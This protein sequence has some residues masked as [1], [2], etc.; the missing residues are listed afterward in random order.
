MPIAEIAICMTF[1]KNTDKQLNFSAQ[2]LVAL[3]YDFVIFEFPTEDGQEQD[4][5]VEPEAPVFD[6]IDIIPDPLRDRGVAPQVIHLCPAGDSR[7]HQVLEHIAWDLFLELFH[8][9]RDLR[10]RPDEAHISL[11]NVPELGKLIQGVFPDKGT[12]AGLPGCR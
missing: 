7:P 3:T 4:L 11:Q 12:E 2:L 10:P 5:Q 9:E 6:I 8:I 1:H